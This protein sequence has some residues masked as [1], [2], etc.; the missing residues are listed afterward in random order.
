MSTEQGI[1]SGKVV[2][3]HYTLTDA[4]GELLD[5]SSGGPPLD[6]LHGSGNIVPGL[7]KGLEGRRAGES[8]RVRVPPGEGYGERDPAGVQQVPRRAFPPDARLE[9]GTAFRAQ[10]SHGG[11]ATVW[12]EKVEGDV[13]TIDLNHPLAGR[14]LEFEVRIESVR[15]A[16]GEELAHGHVHGPHG[17]HHH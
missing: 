17:H 5:S 6:Y 1:A 4:E 11:H 12:I 7:E 8:F 3:F 14:T 16:T 10:D 9:P 15:D 13:V 2:S